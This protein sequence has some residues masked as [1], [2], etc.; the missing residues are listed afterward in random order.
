MILDVK[1]SHDGEQYDDLTHD[2][3]RFREVQLRL[4]D[5]VRKCPHQSAVG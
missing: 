4:A 3:V 5:E 2:P 1:N